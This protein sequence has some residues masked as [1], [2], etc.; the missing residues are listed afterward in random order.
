MKIFLVAILF[1]L[2][3][4]QVSAQQNARNGCTYP[5]IGEIRMFVVFADV[6]DD[7]FS[8]PIPYWPQG[9]L[10][11]YANEVIDDSQQ[12]NLVSYIS[13]YYHEASFGALSVTGDYYPHLLEFNSSEFHDNNNNNIRLQKVVEHLNNI[14]EDSIITHNGH[15]LSY[16]DD[17]TFGSQNERDYHPKLQIP[18]G[19]IDMLVI[20]WRRNSNYK[21]NRDGGTCWGENQENSIKNYGINGFSELCQDN[22]SEIFRHEFG[23]TLLGGNSYHT[24]GAG[25]GAGGHF[26]S[27]VGGYSLLSSHNHNLES[28]N[29][30]D[31]WWL[32]WKHPDKIYDISALDTNGNEVNADIAYIKNLQPRDYI[33]RDF[34]EYGDAVRIKLPY[35]RKDDSRVRNQYLWIE[36]H[37][38]K[39]GSLEST[40]N[41]PK[42]IRFNI[43]VGNDSLTGNFNNSR[44]NYFIPLSSFG[45]YDFVYYP[46]QPQSP[47]NYKAYAYDSRSNPFEGHHPAMMPAI[48]Y[49]GDDTIKPKEFIIIKKLFKENRLKVDDWTV[50]GNAYDAFPIGAKIGLSSN[51][52]STPLMTYRTSIR[53][54]KNSLRKRDSIPET[55]DNRTIW[56]NGLSVKIVGKDSNGDIRIRVCFDDYQVD[57]NVRWCG[58]IMLTENVVLSQAKTIDIDYGYTPIRPVNPSIINDEK[59]F[60]SPTVFTCRDSS[61]FKQE[62]FSTVNV[63]NMSTLVLESGSL[64][65]IEDNAVLNIQSTGT[66]LVKTGA[67]LRI[68]GTGH[69]EVKGGAHICIED[70]ANIELVDEL[71]ALNLRH[72]Y[73]LGLNPSATPLQSNCT[74]S[75]LTNFALGAGSLGQINEWSSANRYIQDTTYYGNAYEF[76]NSIQA[77]YDVTIQKPNGNVILES[78]S[79][80]IIDAEY[81]VKLEPGV[82]VELGAELE[83]RK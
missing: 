61:C 5:S 59:I 74:S 73:Q 70:G 77:G 15:S 16:F 41:P 11:E 82:V 50:Y 69:V 76:G 38:I 78:G 27:N 63:K 36:N 58:T 17:W 33:L 19:K 13:K 49:D 40:N 43:Q 83:V 9:S 56:L 35:L 10:P 2:A 51:P 26:L 25:T 45:N 81:E 37:Q 42:G 39:E 65:E 55:D 18:D 30:W 24:G 57:S 53:N 67:T 68:K 71:S 34:I 23:H 46:D 28:C 1:V 32:G 79:H 75:P 52:P 66:L 80:V 62:S 8:R 54:S 12:G 64:Y 44:T 48:D 47:N 6:V 60:S 29:G 72:G 4:C 7:T 22:P 3:S 14:P 21:A 20:V 31:R